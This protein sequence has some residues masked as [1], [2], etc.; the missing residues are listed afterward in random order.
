MDKIE[1]ISKVLKNN[2]NLDDKLLY[3]LKN[4]R[5]KELTTRVKNEK[6]HYTK[7]SLIYND[8]VKSINNTIIWNY[9]L[10]SIVIILIILAFGL[11]YK[12]KYI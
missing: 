4:K 8:N 7:K 9:I 2:S 3:N 12:F 10:L 1:K 5:L 11:I 6:Q